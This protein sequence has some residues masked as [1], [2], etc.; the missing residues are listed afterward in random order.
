M[1]R[2]QQNPM[3]EAVGMPP[4]T[5]PCYNL[6]HSLTPP[7]YSQS[8]RRRPRKRR[9]VAHPR[10][11]RPRRRLTLWPRPSRILPHQT[12][13]AP[14]RQRPTLRPR[15]RQCAE[16]ELRPRAA[17]RTRLEGFH[18][19]AAAPG[20]RSQHAWPGQAEGA[21]AHGLVVGD[22]QGEP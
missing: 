1:F 12:P 20:G 14:Q 3:E 6:K 7:T 19:C 11:L 21:G 22:V 9:L 5:L 18:R 8:D 13:G 16:P 15:T 10:R 2:T 17:P 4:T